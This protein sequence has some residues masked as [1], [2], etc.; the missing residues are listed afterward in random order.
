MQWVPQKSPSHGT[1]LAVFAIICVAIV[2]VIVT[3]L[4][5][6]WQLLG[7]STAP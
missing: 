1:K 2:L 4:V 6:A 5:L 7:A 3:I